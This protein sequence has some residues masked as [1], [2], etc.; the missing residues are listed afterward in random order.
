MLSASFNR[1]SLKI[2][3]AVAVSA[4]FVLFVGTAAYFTLSYFGR[5]FKETVSRQQFSH[6]SSL[7]NTIDDKLKISQNALIAVAATAPGDVFTNAD[8]SQRFLDSEAGLLSIFDNG[9]FFI[10]KEGRLISESP[11][12]PNRR[13]RDL[14]FREWVQR[15][16]TS[17]K[18]Y[19]SEPY[20][21]THTPGQ[22][23][24]VMT[25][26]IFDSQGRFTGMMTGSFGLLGEN[27][28][29]SLSRIKVGKDGYF[30]ISDEKRTMLV[31]PDKIRIMKLAAPPGA[32]KLFDRLINGFEGSGETVNSSGIAMLTSGKRLHMAPWILAANSPTSEVYGPLSTARH[33]FI[34]A[35]MAGTTLL[36]LIT[37][38]VMRHLMSPLVVVTRHV[39]QLQQKTGEDR[40]IIVDTADEIGVLA[41]AFNVMIGTLDEQRDEL[42]DQKMKIEDERVFLQ[43]MMDAIPDLVFFKDRDSIYRRCNDS[44]ASLF[45]GLP[46][47][48]ILGHND[49]DFV[50]TVEKAGHYQKTDQE[51]MLSAQPCRYEV[52]VE[53]SD[54][55]R[56]LI[57]TLKVPLRDALGH[58]AGVIGI[59]RDI[60]EH[61]RTEETL[62]EQALLLEREIG[63]RQMA[64]E[65]LAANQRQLEVMNGSLEKRITE[66]VTE[67]RRKDQMLIQ[68]S[69]QASMG[70]MINNIAHQ[71]RQPLNNLGLIVQN[72]KF[73]FESGELT[74]EKMKA[75]VSLAMGTIMFMSRTIDDF[76]NF[77]RNDKEKQPF[78]LN[79][80]VGRSIEFLS[81][82]LK[83]LKIS[84]DLEENDSITAVGYPNEYSQVMLNILSNSK[85]V[86]AELQV[87]SPRIRIRVFRENG[88]AVVTVWDNGG[89]IDELVLPRIFDP[90]FSTKE[91]GK[92]TGIGL[93]MSKVIIEKNMGGNIAAYNIDGGVEFRIEIKSAEACWFSPDSDRV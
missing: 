1:I 51:V 13:G 93:Y 62:H 2:K 71:W 77:F 5:T 76:R 35:T 67:L 58:I 12:R 20:I 9:I 26:P 75:E 64:Q 61:K 53:L 25:V 80:M 30:Y 41:T 44:F 43:T 45:V 92:G 19:I 57:E 8:N 56:M 89:G 21:S 23:A 91:Q 82:S 68:Q 32:N 4:L 59:S 74:E 3:V 11:Y 90:Y 49:Y 78:S 34:I 33:Y 42:N 87:I 50:N 86:L 18:P 38:L 37:W 60:T 88:N 46:K 73:D 65:A 14:W 29:A 6:V 36:L 52:W 70:E 47:D 66:T 54:G 85:D 69:R 28:L 16:V 10:S 17:R 63:E 15:T 24:I 48:T 72:L 81:A 40:L 79:S 7:A 22:P 31:H 84:V 83:N 39:R 55:C 27:I